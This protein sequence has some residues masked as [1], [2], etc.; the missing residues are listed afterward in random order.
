[1]LNF[2]VADDSYCNVTANAPI[3]E[4]NREDFSFDL[5]TWTDPDTPNQLH[6]WCGV[7]FCTEDV[8]GVN[9]TDLVVSL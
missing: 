7:F 3:F 4:P 6:I 8:P 5:F 9:C 1:M 2:R